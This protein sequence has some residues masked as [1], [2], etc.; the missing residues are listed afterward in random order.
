VVLKGQ[1]SALGDS[2]IVHRSFEAHAGRSPESIALT[3]HAQ[4]VS[5]RQLNERANQ[6]AHHLMSAGV[7]PGSI[8][9]ICLDRSVELIVAIL[10]IMKAGAAYVPLDPAHPAG[11]L[12]TMCGQLDECVL[13]IASSAT[14]EL[15][16]G[17]PREVGD[18]DEICSAARTLPRMN[19]EVP[20]GP[21]DLCYA[22]FTS[23]STGIPKATAVRHHGW[24]NLLRWL[25]AEYSLDSR[26][27]SLT[28]SSLGFDISQRAMMAPLFTGATLHLLPSRSFDVNM[29]YG[30]MRDEGVRTLHCA[31]SAIYLLA[32]H[33]KI[34]GGDAMKSLDYIF[35]GGEA[36]SVARIID[37]ASHPENRCILVNQYGVAECS[38]V[39]TA[40]TLTNCRDYLESP[41]PAGYPIHNN[42]IRLL[43]ENLHEVPEGETGEICISGVSVGAGYL[44]LPGANAGVFTSITDNGVPVQIYRTGDRGYIKDGQLFLVGRIDNQVKVRGMRIDLG[45]IEHAVRS[46][47]EVRDATVLAVPGPGDQTQLVAFILVAGEP[48]DPRALRAE[49]LKSI[50][51]SM[52]PHKFVQLTEFPLI[53]NGKVDRKAL[54]AS[55]T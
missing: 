9:T 10:G 44:N 16:K 29:A 2:P 32:E 47:P 21:D 25:T 17:V 54:A 46:Q 37:W 52:V 8:V 7:K 31:P 36:L 26:S 13:I 49:L 40:H 18:I 43:D 19:P 38:D 53:P 11:R 39:A 41:V 55:L 24:F 30:I 27:S 12:R 51:P 4:R 33:E 50:P 14:R 20:A 28:V 3:C 35:S 23:G 45:D 22:V 6:F 1:R 42:D 15:L 5:Y 48:A 34:T